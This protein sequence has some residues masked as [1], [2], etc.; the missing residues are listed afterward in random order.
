MDDAMIV[1]M[2]R[3]GRLVVPKAIRESY[4]QEMNDFCEALNKGCMRNRVDYI[5]MDT[6]QP[7]DVALSSYLASRIGKI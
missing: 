7:L 3:A 6:S 1:T 2:D 5:R 4:L